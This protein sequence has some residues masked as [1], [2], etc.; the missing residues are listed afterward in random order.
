MSRLAATVLALLVLAIAIVPVGDPATQDRNAPFQTPGSTHYLG[1]DG[2]GRDVLARVVAGS[3]LSLAAGVLATLI[4]M[5]IA[6]CLGAVAGY[7]QGWLDEGTMGAAELFLSLPWIYLVLGIRA[8]LPL[9]LS[10][11]KALFAIAF[12]AGCTGW[13]RASRLIR[14]V[15]LADSGKPYVLAARAFGGGPA[16]LLRRHIIPDAAPVILVQA[17]LLLPQFIL[18]EVTLSFL[19]LGIGEPA[20]SLGGML[21]ALRDMHVLTSYPWMLAPAAVVLAITAGCQSCAHWLQSK[22]PGLH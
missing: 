10:P 18:G 9:S 20:P 13:P 5:A 17:A 1:T 6:I 4:A 21:S 14:G 11:A 2:L 22:G 19:G 16:Y 15:V 12:V 8:L 7:F 3:R